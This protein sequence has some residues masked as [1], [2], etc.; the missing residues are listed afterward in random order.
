MRGIEGTKERHV[1]TF[2]MTISNTGGKPVDYN[3]E[4]TY[5]NIEKEWYYL[6]PE[7]FPVCQNTLSELLRIV[8]NMNAQPRTKV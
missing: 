1:K 6:L 7:N 4:A 3:V 5:N 8:K 2:V